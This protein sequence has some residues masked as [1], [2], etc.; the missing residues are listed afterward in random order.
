MF[1]SWTVHVLV[2]SEAFRACA[3]TLA[4]LFGTRIFVVANDLA[5]AIR[6]FVLSGVD[7]VLEQRLAVF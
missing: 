6:P 2:I 1:F 7:P 5:L 3:V 4:K